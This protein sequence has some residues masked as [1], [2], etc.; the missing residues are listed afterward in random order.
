ME[1]LVGECVRFIADHL[2]G[3]MELK[4]D[5]TNNSEDILARL[6]KVR[7][8]WNMLA[9]LI[10]S[11][12]ELVLCPISSGNSKTWKPQAAEACIWRSNFS[13]S[14]KTVLEG[15]SEGFAPA[16]LTGLGNDWWWD[17]TWFCIVYS[18]QHQGWYQHFFCLFLIT[19]W[20]TAFFMHF[21][22]NMSN[23]C[24]PQRKIR[25]RKFEWSAFC[26]IS[27]ATEWKH[28]TIHKDGTV[29]WIKKHTN[30]TAANILAYWMEGP[31]SHCN[32]WIVLVVPTVPT[33]LACYLPGISSYVKYNWPNNGMVSTVSRA[34][35]LWISSEPWWCKRHWS[36]LCGKSSAR[37]QIKI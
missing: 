5:I 30:L 36:T 23:K 9:G 10:G 24:K 19:G 26:C 15:I 2:E 21:L 7:G 33:F 11:I 28:S 27:L 14:S 37:M 6:A 13:I 35:F 20:S 31:H 25:N 17:D 32:T 34:K 29:L 1:Q 22:Q 12:V 16:H 4:V 18:W 3:I 8:C